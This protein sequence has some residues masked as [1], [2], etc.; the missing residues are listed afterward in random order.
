MT[1]DKK[2]GKTQLGD[3]THCKKCG[4]YMQTDSFMSAYDKVFAATGVCEKCS[5][6]KRKMAARKTK[7]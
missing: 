4:S 3:D 5:Q 2:P 1:R 7:Q 6:G